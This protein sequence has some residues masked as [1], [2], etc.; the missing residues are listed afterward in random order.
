[1]KIPKG[2]NKV[3]RS[4]MRNLTKNIGKSGLKKSEKNDIKIKRILITRPN[5][6]LGNLLLLSP[7][8]QEVINTFPESKIDLFVKGQITPIIYKNYSNIDK[9][10]QLP[11]KPF[12]NIFKYLKGW[13]SLRTRKYDLVIN[14]N[15]GSS[16]G[17]ISTLAANSRY[18]MFGEFDEKYIQQFNDYQ[19]SAKQSIYD[20]RHFLSELGV[21][22]N[23]NDIPFLDIKLD[24]EE[25]EAGKKKLFSIIQNNKPTICL[26]T[27]ATGDK[28]YSEQW[29]SD[30]YDTLKE[31]FPD[32][33][34]VELLPVENISKLNFAI[35]HFYSKDIREMGGFIANTVVFIAA[36]NGVMHLASAS[37]T[38]TVGLFKVTDENLYKP[39][40]P[41]SFSVNTQQ[42]TNKDIMSLLRTTIR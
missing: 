2:I 8:V 10:I 16:S 34:I 31:A 20:L 6:R 3:R 26:F 21:S 11:K 35:P 7:L 24:A 19:H 39:Y 30:F 33:N 1:M 17:R 40:N 14:A 42:N 28:C 37:G 38:P 41:K 25:I 12:S 29:W 32:Y 9:I 13:V 27:N 23:K 18:K 36:D 5:H 15:F 4:L 22:E